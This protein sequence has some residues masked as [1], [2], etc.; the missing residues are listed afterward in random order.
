MIRACTTLGFLLP[1]LVAGVGC[2]GDS[3]RAAVSGKVT[4]DGLPVEQGR[5]T[6]IPSEG[7]QGATAGAV[8]L[9]GA[10]HVPAS[11]GVVI[12][13]NRVE[14]HATR[15]TSKQFPSA[16][17][18]KPLDERAEVVPARY[19]EKSE[20]VRDIRPGKNVLDFDLESK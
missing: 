2:S 13:T 19:N 15:K 6:F 14:I 8:I 16:Y 17:T 4:L 5:I 9:N 18:G 7:N 10:Y 11:N 1:A 12:G 20:L 3:N